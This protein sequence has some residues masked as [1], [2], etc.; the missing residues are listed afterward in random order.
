MPTDAAWL[1]I[2]DIIAA[3]LPYIEK[4]FGPYP[5]KQYSL[6]MVVMVAWNTNGT[7]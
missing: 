1:R 4:T 7:Y 6:Y 5:Y 3:A 2:L